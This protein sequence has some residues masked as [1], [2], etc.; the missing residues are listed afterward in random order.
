[1]YCVVI[2]RAEQEPKFLTCRKFRASGK[3]SILIQNK[4][5]D[6]WNFLWEGTF[7]EELKWNFSKMSC[8][9]AIS[10]PNC[11]PGSQCSLGIPDSP[12]AH[13]ATASV[14]HLPHG[15]RLARGAVGEAGSS[16]WRQPTW[17]VAQETENL[18]C[19]GVG[20]PWCWEWFLTENLNFADGEFSTGKS[21]W[22]S[23]LTCSSNCTGKENSSTINQERG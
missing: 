21:F 7:W 12:A 20:E 10:L 15:G 17:W 3:K 9:P 6:L 18:G 14:P 4:K 2:I 13:L 8:F 22:C 1:M 23:F 5:L 19:H 16:A 11:V